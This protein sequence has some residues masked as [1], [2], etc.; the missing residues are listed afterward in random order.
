MKRP[1]WPGCIL[2]L[3]ETEAGSSPETQAETNVNTMHWKSDT[4]IDPGWYWYKSKSHRALMLR[5]DDHGLVDSHGEF[6]GTQATKLV[7]DWYTPQIRP[8]A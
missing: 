2:V 8:P 6:N 5:I 3:S 1:A 4:P 7:G